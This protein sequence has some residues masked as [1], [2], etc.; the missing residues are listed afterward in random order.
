MKRRGPKSAYSR[1]P[2]ML[3]RDRI[4]DRRHIY[5]RDPGDI[6]VDTHGLAH[7]KG[8]RQPFHMLPGGTT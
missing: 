8:G 2:R 5:Y 6:C 4:G 1:W 3:R 7:I